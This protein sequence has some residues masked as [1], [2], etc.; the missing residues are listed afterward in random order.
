MDQFTFDKRLPLIL[1]L[2]G[3]FLLFTGIVVFIA[4]LGGE[5]LPNYDLHIV[6]L[7]VCE[8]NSELIMQSRFSQKVQ[9]LYVCGK[10]DGTTFQHGYFYVFFNDSVIYQQR[11]RIELGE[12][13]WKI[14]KLKDSLISYQN[15]QYRIEIYE[16]KLKTAQASFTIQ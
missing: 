10:A 14:P 9:Q 1:K 2:G 12:F 5:W 16:D 11:V 6:E 8:N 13:F 15:G 7:G 3:V 4:Y